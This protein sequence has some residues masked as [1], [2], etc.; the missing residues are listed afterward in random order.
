LLFIPEPFKGA[1]P[2]SRLTLWLGILSKLF[3]L[4]FSLF[5]KKE[6]IIPDRVVE[7]K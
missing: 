1:V 4:S 7:I 6:I 2:A 3:D 5:Y